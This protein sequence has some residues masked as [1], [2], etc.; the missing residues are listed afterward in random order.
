M[1][2]LC[3]GG[4]EP[5]PAQDLRSLSRLTAHERNG[6]IS[7]ALYK[8]GLEEGI[9]PYCTVAVGYRVMLTWQ[10]KRRRD[11][12]VNR[13]WEAGGIPL[14]RPPSLPPAGKIKTTQR[15]GGLLVFPLIVRDRNERPR[16]RHGVKICLAPPPP[17][18]SNLELLHVAPS[19]CFPFS[20]S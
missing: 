3:V 11:K 17:S 18:V 2:G 12:L 8:G 16:D 20:K 15:G 14:K 13:C 1:A 9:P 6:D 19:S 4:N 7:C 10:Q 5:S